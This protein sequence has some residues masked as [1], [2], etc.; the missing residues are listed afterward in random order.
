MYESFVSLRAAADWEAAGA[1]SV[2]SHALAEAEA[3][4]RQALRAAEAEAPSRG[5]D[6]LIA[7]IESILSAF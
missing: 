3:L 5:R 6:Q 4:F 7:R 1:A 2:R